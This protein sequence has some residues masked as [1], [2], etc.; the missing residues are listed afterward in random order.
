MTHVSIIAPS[1]VRVNVPNPLLRYTFNPVH[2]SFPPPFN[3]WRT[4]LRQPNRNGV[5]NINGLIGYVNT[6][7]LYYTQR[8]T[9]YTEFSSP[10]G[11]KF[12]RRHCTC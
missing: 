2:P 5:E 9:L 7:F 6:L 10:Q 8:I 3:T 4:T 11:D 1:G 12:E